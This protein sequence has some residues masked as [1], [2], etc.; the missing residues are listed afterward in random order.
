MR[1]S[2]ILFLAFAGCTSSKAPP[3]EPVCPPPL[4][5]Q[6]PPEAGAW[7]PEA[8]L[9]TPRFP[10]TPLLERYLGEDESSGDDR[11]ES[12]RYFDNASRERYRVVA[13]GGRLVDRQG[14]PL[15]PGPGVG[16]GANDEAIY[17]MDAAGNHYA[18]FSQER[19]RVH[20]SSLLA[21]APVAAAGTLA[22]EQGRLKKM[23]NYSGHYRPGTQTLEALRARLRQMGVDLSAVEVIAA[24]A[25]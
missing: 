25:E 16:A 9:Y 18:T 1:T 21:G 11:V 17:V 23:S 19:G 12:V 15:D 2:S 20:H 5:A 24:V 13:R 4:A 10:T 14:R 8:P 7:A 3:A 6:A 22:I